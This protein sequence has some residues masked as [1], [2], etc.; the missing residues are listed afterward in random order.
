MLVFGRIVPAVEIPENLA[1]KAVASASSEYSGDYSA[2]FA[3]DGNVPGPGSRQDVRQ[4]WCCNGAKSGG[5]AEFVL[6]WDQPV[7]VAEIVCWGRTAQ[8][9]SECWK[10]YEVYFDQEALPAANGRFSMIHGPQRI[11]AAKQAT[12]KVRLKF[13]S[14]YE[15]G[16]NH[17]ASEIAVY[18]SRPSDE[19]L[20]LFPL[21]GR[22]LEEQIRKAEVEQ[23]HLR[24]AASTLRGKVA[25][26][27][28]SR[29]HNAVDWTAPVMQPPTDTMPARG[30]GYG[31]P[32]Q[33]YRCYTEK[34]TPGPSALGKQLYILD[35]AQPQSSPRL[36]VDAGNG[37]I[38]GAMCV[39]FDGNTIYFAMAPDGEPFFHIYRLAVAGGQPQQ[40]T[41]GTFHD[42]DPDILPDGRIVFSSTRFGGREEYHAY[43]VS[44]LFTMSAHGED[45]QPLTYHCGQ[46]PGTEGH[47]RRQHRVRASGQFLHECEDRDADP[48]DSCG[49]DVRDD[50]PRSGSRGQRL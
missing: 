3:V 35:P 29:P 22:E 2:K 40:L 27:S 4:A 9:M 21:V 44:T 8:L 1:P 24:R 36:L 50:A 28:G 30:L 10:D 18:S 12:R 41:R 25:F 48:P 45:I 11:A 23:V 5:K 31:Q 42:V 38:G 16:Q 39:S 7:D 15:G 20:D 43:L 6:E 34:D 32:G 13:L 19:Q 37:W 47:R 17:G 49:R 14:G 46:R 26:L 33:T